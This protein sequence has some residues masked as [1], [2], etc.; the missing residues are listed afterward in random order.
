[1]KLALL[2]L[3]VFLGLYFVLQAHKEKLRWPSILRLVVKKRPEADG[4]VACRLLAILHAVLVC[5]LSALSN[6]VIGPWA[7]SAVGEVNT[8][9]QK[10]VLSC[11]LSEPGLMIGHHGASIFCCLLSLMTN[12]SGSEVVGC[13]FGAEVSNPFLQA[14]WFMLE[15]GLRETRACRIIE[16]TFALVFLSCRVFWA[17]TLL[18]VVVASPKPPQTIKVGA[19]LL[20]IIS[21]TWSFFVAKKLFAAFKHLRQND[22]Q[23]SK[24]QKT[25]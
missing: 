11:D 2:S 24:L 4:E 17:P 6:L 15:A 19:V 23:E 25:E 21:W 14:R 12:V 9:F 22:N 7:Y 8:A 20:Q 3:G 5:I 1:M 13:L 16:V 18:W 10:F